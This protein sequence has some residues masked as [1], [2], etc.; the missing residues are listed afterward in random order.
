MTSRVRRTSLTEMRRACFLPILLFPFFL[1]SCG[2]AAVLCT[3][4]VFRAAAPEVVGA[5]KA[6]WPWRGAGTVDL[7]LGAGLGGVKAALDELPPGV[8][9]LVGVALS[10]PERRELSA[11]S[12]HRL[13][14]FVPDAQAAAVTVERAAAWEAVAKAAASS[15]A[16]AVLFPSDSLPGERDR[17]EQAWRNA[18]GGPLTSW[19][20]PRVGE[21]WQPVVFQWAGPDAD[22]RVLAL[23]AKTEVHG[24]PGTVRPPG[25]K[26]LT[27]GLREAGLG[28]FLW[29]W[30]FATDKDLHFLPLETVPA[31]R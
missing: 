4:G 26:G 15:Q 7:P 2:P 30:A 13:V 10:A 19:V 29:S 1:A 20:W 16:A 12:R 5:W 22:S 25:S 14:Y 23:S 11:A 27:W 3:D 24:D 8:P 6:L 28:E 17:F 31:N 18:G 21:L 9:V